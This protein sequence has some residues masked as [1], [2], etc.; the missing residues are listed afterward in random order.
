MLN[1][2]FGC[3]DFQ[4]APGARVWFVGADEMRITMKRRW[5]IVGCRQ[6]WMNPQRDGALEL[7]VF[8][9][10]ETTGMTTKSQEEEEEE[11]E[12]EEEEQ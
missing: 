7:S 11:D 10:T 3:E 12:E 2:I 8:F 5:E 4:L 9:L 1:Q 6:R